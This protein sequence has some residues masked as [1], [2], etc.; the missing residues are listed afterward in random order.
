MVRQK[1][2][3]LLVNILY[4]SRDESKAPN[5]PNVVQFH[6]PSSPK[7]EAHMLVRAIRDLVAFHF[8]DYGSGMISASFAVKYFSPATSTVIIRVA[9][10]HWRLVWAALTFMQ[11]LPKPVDE[12]C[13]IQVVHVSGTIRKAEE[14]AIRRAR[15]AV[16]KARRQATELTWTGTSIVQAVSHSEIMDLAA[17]AT[18]DDEVGEVVARSSGSDLSEDDQG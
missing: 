17:E 10:S 11:R 7:L 5:Q 12:A 18:K 2:R 16:L 1:N 9:R 4:P 8:G 15:E 13:V 14:E 3:Y 6:Q